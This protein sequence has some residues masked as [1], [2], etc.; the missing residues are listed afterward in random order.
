MQMPLIASPLNYTGGKFRLLPQILPF[1][2][3][4]IN[5]FID[6]FCGGCNVGLN[7][8]SKKTIYNDINIKLY[9]LYNFLKKM[10]SE[11]ILKQIYKIIEK[12]DLS[13]VSKYGYEFYKC[14]SSKGLS[15]YNKNGYLKLRNDFN[16]ENNTSFDY[17]IMFYVMIVYAFNNQIRFNSKGNF[18]LPVGK[19]DFNTKMEQK[20][21][22]FIKRIQ[23]Q[24]CY[25]SC[26]DFRNFNIQN[27]EKNDFV[28]IDP[29]YLIT[30]ATYNENSSWNE[31]DEKDLLDFLEKLDNQ[32]IRFALSNVLSSKGKTNEILKHWL[33]NKKY[34]VHHLKHKY[35]NSN[36]Q[37]KDKNFTSDEVLIINY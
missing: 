35:S 16:T 19:R 7:V 28:Y 1:F 23:E 13:I 27:L 22:N 36:Y 20:L 26:I 25:F 33:K 3:K 21:I 4:N 30:C 15:K 37:I 29:P 14:D 10:D 6:L 32:N 11:N 2:P 34:K 9:D 5:T 24:N 8:K 12:Y 31:N 18:N 17:Y